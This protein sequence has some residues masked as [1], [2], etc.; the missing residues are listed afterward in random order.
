MK[1]LDENGLSRLWSDFK[2]YVNNHFKATAY[3]I[4]TGESNGWTYREWSN[5]RWEADRV[6]I[7]TNVSFSNKVGSSNYFHYTQN[8][9]PDLNYFPK[10]YDPDTVICNCN[11]NYL[12]LTTPKVTHNAT[13]PSF[14]LNFTRFVNSSSPALSEVRVSVHASGK[15]NL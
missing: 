15:T 11:E 13:P 2:T 8:F 4:E 6:I 3:V 12:I 5:G 14:T 10:G 9:T 7:A 1:F